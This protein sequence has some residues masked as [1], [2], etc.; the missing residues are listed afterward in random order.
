MHI[1]FFSLVVLGGGGIGHEKG[2]S[3]HSGHRSI[4][5]KLDAT[6]WNDGYKDTS[7]TRAAVHG[8]YHGAVGAYKIAQGNSEGAAAEFSRAGDI[9]TMKTENNKTKPEDNKK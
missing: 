9:L 5:D 2:V 4:S 7:V 1:I 8:T 6:V 3:N